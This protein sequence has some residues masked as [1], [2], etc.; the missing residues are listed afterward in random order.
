MALMVHGQQVAPPTSV[1]PWQRPWQTVTFRV[2]AP[3]ICRRSASASSRCLC[4]FLARSHL[5]V[6]APRGHGTTLTPHHGVFQDPW[7]PAST[8]CR[9]LT[10]R[11]PELERPRCW[12]FLPPVFPVLPPG[13]R[14]PAASQTAPIVQPIPSPSIACQCVR[15]PP[16]D[17]LPSPAS[18]SPAP[19]RGRP[20]S[21]CTAPPPN[22]GQRLRQSGK[23]AEARPMSFHYTISTC[24]AA[25]ARRPTP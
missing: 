5:Y 15:S 22:A 3:A 17:T 9:A 2:A 12:Q 23:P 8:G 16:F 7:D 18:T 13:N 24:T 21:S 4:E 25:P 14:S 20:S 6:D 11:A 1:Q 19:G 10:I